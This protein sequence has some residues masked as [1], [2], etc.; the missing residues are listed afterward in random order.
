MAKKGTLEG[1]RSIEQYQ[2]AMLYFHMRTRWFGYNC[3]VYKMAQTMETKFGRKSF[4]G[5]DLC[6]LES[7][8][9][10]IPYEIFELSV[11]VRLNLELD[12][13]IE[14]KALLKKRKRRT[15]TLSRG[16]IIGLEDM[17]PNPFD[18]NQVILK[19]ICFKTVRNMRRLHAEYSRNNNPRVILWILGAHSRILGERPA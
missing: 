12:F 4:Q 19:L 9:E 17:T 18:F 14:P 3:L 10:L 6:H 5:A 13:G 2:P 15:W 16:F 8:Y 7:M 11:I 1:S